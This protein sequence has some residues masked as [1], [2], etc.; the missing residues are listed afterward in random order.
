MEKRLTLIRANVCRA[1]LLICMMLL[2]R[3]VNRA[4]LDES[5]T[6]LTEA[7]HELTAIRGH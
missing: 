1:A 7:L 4:K 6:L 2:D 5:I 3:K